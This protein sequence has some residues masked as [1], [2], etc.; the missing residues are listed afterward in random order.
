M[1]LANF[2]Q[3]NYGDPLISTC[4]TKPAR[5]YV[6]FQCTVGERDIK[7]NVKSS[8]ISVSLGCAGGILYIALFYFHMF[9]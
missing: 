7:T 5:V 6:Q 4:I 3:S 9:Q 2:V 8:N 1:N